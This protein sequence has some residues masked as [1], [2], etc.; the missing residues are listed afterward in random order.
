MTCYT[1]RERKLYSLTSKTQGLYSLA[2]RL[3]GSQSAAHCPCSRFFL[4]FSPTILGFYLRENGQ[5]RP[6]HTFGIRR[7]YTLTAP[8]QV[9][10]S[11]AG[12]TA[13]VPSTRPRSSQPAPSIFLSVGSPV[14]S[15]ALGIVLARCLAGFQS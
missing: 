15:I 14:E 5:T 8:V 6:L 2:Q 3:K 9:V 10:V 13:V 1:S 12:L 7:Y 11:D 4:I